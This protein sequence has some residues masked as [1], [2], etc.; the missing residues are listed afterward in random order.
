MSKIGTF[1]SS[2]DYQSVT[3]MADFRQRKLLIQH[4]FAFSK[5]IQQ[6]F[7]GIRNN[8][9]LQTMIENMT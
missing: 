7:F 3:E 8:V 9:V 6:R 5:C 4:M 2:I 1:F